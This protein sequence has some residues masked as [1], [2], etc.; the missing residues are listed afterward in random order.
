MKKRLGFTLME[1]LCVVAIIAICMALIFPAVQ[2]ARE[3][4]RRMTCVSNSKQLGLAFSAYHDS[5]QKFP[6][7]GH[8]VRWQ[9]ALLPFLGQSALFSQYD[10]NSGPDSAFN[11]GF[12]KSMPSILKCPSEQSRH[13]A[14]SQRQAAHKLANLL[15]L[16]KSL[17]DCTDGTSYTAMAVEL[18]SF[19]EIPWTYGPSHLIASNDSAH[20]SITVVLFVAGNVRTVRGDDSELMFKLG[21]PDGEE[22]IWWQN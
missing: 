21:T 20:G 2:Q 1:L 5:H 7:I 13:H 15:M 6:L 9:V 17:K 11:I 10:Q 12:G 4:A 22:V 8:H 19:N 14:P 16:D 18:R 3:T